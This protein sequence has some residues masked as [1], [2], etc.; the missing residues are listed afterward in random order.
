MGTT[1]ELVK[2]ILRLQLEAHF[3]S[4]DLNSTGFNLDP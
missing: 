2:G 1:G 3:I 4:I